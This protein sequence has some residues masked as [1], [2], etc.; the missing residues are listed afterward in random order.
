MSNNNLIDNYNA[1]GIAEGFVECDSEEEYLEAWQHLVDTG[2]AW[3]LQGWFGRTATDLIER[4]VIT[5]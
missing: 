3:S 1:V 2:L 4:G 5:A